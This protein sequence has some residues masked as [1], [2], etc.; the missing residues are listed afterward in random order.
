MKYYPNDIRDLV[1]YLKTFIVLSVIPITSQIIKTQH[2]RF[3]SL[4]IHS[5]ILN[6]YFHFYT[7]IMP[8]WIYY[9]MTQLYSQ[10]HGLRYLAIIPFQNHIS[11]F[12]QIIF[13]YLGLQS[14]L[15]LIISR[16]VVLGIKYLLCGLEFG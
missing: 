1:N 15:Y 5:A 11:H 7:I 12:L 8:Y 2:C 6:F 10:I 3:L 14:I 4:L 13:V 9:L 16:E